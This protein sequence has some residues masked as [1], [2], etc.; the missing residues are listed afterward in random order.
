MPTIRI[1]QALQKI[2]KPAEFEDYLIGSGKPEGVKAT[3][4][5]EEVSWGEDAPPATAPAPQRE[6]VDYS[7]MTKPQIEAHVRETYGV[8]LD[9][10][11][12]KSELVAQ[13]L[14]IALDN[15]G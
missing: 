10:R 6:A 14:R 3:V 4:S 2:M 5:G 11:Y 1:T 9:R 15:G 7:K 12:K 13:A 8:E